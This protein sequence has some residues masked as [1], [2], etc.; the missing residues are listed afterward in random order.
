M[1]HLWPLQHLSRTACRSLINHPDNHSNWKKYVSIET[2]E[3]NIHSFN[4]QSSAFVWGVHSL[5]FRV[6]LQQDLCSWQI[7]FL[8]AGHPPFIP[9][10]FNASFISSMLDDLRTTIC[11]TTVPLIIVNLYHSCPN[12]FVKAYGMRMGPLRMWDLVGI[13]LFGRERERWGAGL[14]VSCSPLVG[15]DRRYQPTK[16][17]VWLFTREIPRKYH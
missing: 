12:F 14:R 7:L 16:H 9:K 13:D 10:S 6:C 2:Y 15:N 11:S 1:V 17:W 5:L 8:I 3:W 4:F